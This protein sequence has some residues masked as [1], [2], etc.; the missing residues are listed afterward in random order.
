[1]RVFLAFSIALTLLISCNYKSQTADTVF[2]NAYIIDCDGMGNEKAEL[3]AIAVLDG[4]IV[5]IGAEQA[6]RNAYSADEFIDLKKVFVYPG[7]IDAHSHFLGYSLNKTKVDL[8]GTT[9]YKDVLER[10]VH[11]ASNYLSAS[12]ST[13]WITGRGWDQND[14]Q[15]AEYPTRYEL[16][17]L[18]PNRPVAVR[19]IDGHALL[20]NRVALELAGIFDLVNENGGSIEGGEIVLLADSTPSGVLVDE[21]SDLLLGIVPEPD[22]STKRLA[23]IEGEKDLFAAGLTTV[24]DAGLDVSDIKLI[25]E[26]HSSG[27]LKIRVIAMA[28]GTVP[29]LDSALEMGPWR[30]DRLVAESIKFY[31]DGALGSRGAALLKPYSDRPNYSGYLIQDSTLYKESLFKAHE[32]GFQVCTHGIGDRAVRH[33][34]EEYNSV[35]GGVNDNR[36]RIEHSQVVSTEDLSLYES[37]SIIPSVQ[38]THATS[39]MYWAAE[40]LGKGRI[41]RAYRYLDLKNILGMLPLGT[42]FPIE[43]IEPIKTFYAA[44]IRKDAEGYPE[45]GYYMDQALDRNSALLGMTVWASIANRTELET[46]SIEVGKWADFVVLDRNILTIPEE[47][48]LST[49]VLLT[50]VAGKVVFKANN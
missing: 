44:T 28:S 18:F 31:M 17:S 3:G 15:V 47:N 4:K 41:R 8:V 12:D 46:G 43:G 23:L 19:R 42:D 33:V 9:S 39:D 22:L 26:L 24:T 20:A 50:V 40:R 32:L 36:W 49:K 38:P 14:W 27:D 29:N 13:S 2:H 6:I 45:G 48:I 25:S 5:G 21:A 37:A 11:F 34:L 10:I 35:L 1:M 30:T 7:F 16:D